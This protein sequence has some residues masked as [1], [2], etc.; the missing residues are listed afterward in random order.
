MRT[1]FIEFIK[2]VGESDRM[3]GLSSIL[4]LCCREFNKLINTGARNYLSLDINMT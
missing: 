4:S 1:C 2:Q 3:L